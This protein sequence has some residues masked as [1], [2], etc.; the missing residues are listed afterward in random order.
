MPFPSQERQPFTKAGIENLKTAQKG[1]YGI[2]SGDNKWVYIGKGN[3]IRDRLLQHFNKT[4]EESTCIW[5][6]NPAQFVTLVTNDPDGAEKQLLTEFST[7]CNQ[8]VG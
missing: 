2:I 3:D 1:C 5:K 4:S 8:K 6:Y 7:Y